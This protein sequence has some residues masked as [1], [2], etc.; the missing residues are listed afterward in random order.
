MARWLKHFLYKPDDPVQH[1]ETPTPTAKAGSSSGR[2]AGS[3]SASSRTG[4]DMVA[5]FHVATRDPTA[6]P[7][8]CDPNH[9]PS[10]AHGTDL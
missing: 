6:G 8:A 5:G 10:Q 1:P 3:L 7:H 2:P 4:L 9:L